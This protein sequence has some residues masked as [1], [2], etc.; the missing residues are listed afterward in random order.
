[1]STRDVTPLPC[2]ANATRIAG[3]P[4]RIHDVATGRIVGTFARDADLKPVMTISVGVTTIGAHI[5]S[6][7]PRRLGGSPRGQLIG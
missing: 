2:V 4:A 7:C 1:M 3:K 6:E 5:I